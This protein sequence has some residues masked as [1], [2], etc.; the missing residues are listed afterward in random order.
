[1]KKPSRIKASQLSP[2]AAAARQKAK[3]KGKGKGRQWKAGTSM[4]YAKEFN[5]DLDII[6]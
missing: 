4:P 5:I 6:H 2:E 3:C 1:V